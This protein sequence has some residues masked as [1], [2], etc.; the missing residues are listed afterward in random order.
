MKKTKSWSNSYLLDIPVIDEQHKKLFNIYDNVLNM[1]N[2]KE[3]YGETE[4]KQ[5]LNDL[6]D[7]LNIH[8]QT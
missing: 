6:E 1:I 5:V 4:L 8:F 2:D 7:Y 3:S